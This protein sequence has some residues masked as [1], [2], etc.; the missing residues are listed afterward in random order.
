MVVAHNNMR[1][2]PH[3]FPEWPC[4]EININKIIE[5]LQNN[6][7]PFEGRKSIFDGN[8]IADGKAKIMHDD[9][10]AWFEQV[11]GVKPA[12]LFGPTEGGEIAS[13]PTANQ[14]SESTRLGNAPPE[15]NGRLQSSQY[16]RELSSKAERA[17]KEYPTW[18]TTNPKVQKSGNLHDWLKTTCDFNERE[19]EIVKKVLSDVYKE[20]K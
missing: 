2:A 19:T 16:W 8:V 7:L 11:A 20:L 17:I 4:L 14:P 9:L 13:E 6:E 15:V 12:F 1:P 3:Y 10:K 5:A 18:K